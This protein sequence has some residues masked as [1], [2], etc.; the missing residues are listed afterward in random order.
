MYLAGRFSGEDIYQKA[1]SA[2]SQKSGTKY[3]LVTLQGVD[4]REDALVKCTTLRLSGNAG[5]L[6]TQNNAYFVALATYSSKDLADE[7]IAKNEDLV[8]IELSFNL[9]A[10]L[11]SSRDD[12]IT[13]ECI[14]SYQS[15]ILNLENLINDYAKKELT[16]VE[17][18]HSLESEHSAL[19]NLKGKIIEQNPEN[20]DDLI[21]LLD[22]PI[23]GLNAII[24]AS[25]H[26]TLLGEL[27][28]VMTSAVVALTAT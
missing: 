6:Y 5:Y 27:R 12:A 28:Y 7:V 22:V 24:G 17:T 9:S 16:L 14:E 3:Y 10:M 20:K 21:A 1:V 11:K 2:L 25:S 19:L 8:L 13:K 4:Y 26:H 23:G 15:T 18:L